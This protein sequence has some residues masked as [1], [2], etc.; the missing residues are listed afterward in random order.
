MHVMV[1]DVMKSIDTV[2]RSILD[3][4]PGRLGLP[5][6]F[7]RVYFSYHSQVRLRF[8]LVAGLGETWCRDGG[9]NPKVVRL[10]W[11]SLL[12]CMFRGV[13]V[14]RLCLVLRSSFMPTISSAARSVLV[15]FLMLPGLLTSRYVRAVGQDVSPGKC[16]L[17]STS[18]SVKKAMMLWD[19]S[20]DGGFWKVQLDVRDLGGHL[21]FTWRARAGTLSKRVGEATVAVAA[22]DAL[23]LGF[24]V[25][26][27]LVRG[28][29]L[30]AGLHAAE[31]PYVSSSPI[32]AFRAAIVR[33]CGPLR[34][35][36]PTPLLSLISL[37][38]L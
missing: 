18:K 20:G 34:C 26:L 30:S 16:V 15:P 33:A 11:C 21:D 7:R 6:R 2:D 17:L 25:K 35:L 4:A 1:A 36:L 22:V 12:L 38:C 28:K 27:G 29:F 24:P 3:W 14:F 37:I 5:D 31:A 19:I 32:N 8:K 10:D 9:K 23:P 13:V